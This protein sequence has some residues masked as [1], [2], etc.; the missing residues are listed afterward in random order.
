MGSMSSRLRF[1]P[2]AS[3]SSPLPLSPPFVC[4]AGAS[5]RRE[6]PETPRRK[7]KTEELD[8]LLASLS[9]TRRVG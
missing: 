8:D 2:D 4:C 6:L 3:P 9:V 7:E 5:T 1:V